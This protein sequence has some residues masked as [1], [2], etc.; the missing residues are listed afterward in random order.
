MARFDSLGEFMHG[1][2][3][4]SNHPEWWAL[5]HVMGDEK[6]ARYLKSRSAKTREGYKDTFSTV[7]IDGF[8]PIRDPKAVYQAEFPEDLPNPIQR[9]SDNL[10]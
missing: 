6:F 9:R 3:G 2:A 5:F 4:E 10:S 8:D 1:A 7:G